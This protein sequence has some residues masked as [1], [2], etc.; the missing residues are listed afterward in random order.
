M[1]N[2]FIR[3]HIFLTDPAILRLSLELALFSICH[4]QQRFHFFNRSLHINDLGLHR[5][6]L[7]SVLLVNYLKVLLCTLSQ[8]LCVSQWSLH[9]LR[10]FHQ[11]TLHQGDALQITQMLWFLLHQASLILDQVIRNGVNLVKGVIT[12]GVEVVLC[13]LIINMLKLWLFVSPVL[14]N[15]TGLKLLL[16]LTGNIAV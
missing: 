11:R 4:S 8:S 9:M 2:I 10:I 16:L 14:L 13:D 12:E 3:R 7:L 5:C 6:C 1:A 15:I